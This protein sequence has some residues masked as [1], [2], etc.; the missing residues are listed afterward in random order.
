MGA[1]NSASHFQKVMSEVMDGLILQ[2]LLVYIDDILVFAD[3][4]EKLVLVIREFFLR[5]RQFG[6]KIKPSSWSSSQ[7]AFFGAV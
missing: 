7:R 6:I 5:L 4:E 1:K 2:N 3:S